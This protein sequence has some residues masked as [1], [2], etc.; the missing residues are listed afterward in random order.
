MTKFSFPKINSEDVQERFK[1]NLVG[2]TKQTKDSRLYVLTKDKTGSGSSVIRFLPGKIVDGKEN[3]PYS[4][5]YRHNLQ[6]GKGGQFVSCICPTTVSQKCPICEWNKM[7]NT[8]WVKKNNT[9]RKRKYLSNVLIMEEATEELIGKVKLMEYG[10][11]IMNI[12]ESKI[13][14]K[15]IG[16]RKKEPL[17]YYDWE[18]GANF[19]LVLS[20][21]KGQS[22]PSWDNSEFLAPT[23]I[24]EFLEDH[25]IDPETIVNNLYDTEEVVSGLDIPSYEKLKADLN[26]WCVANKLPTYSSLE[27][28]AE[29][30]GSF[31]SASDYAEAYHKAQDDIEDVTDDD[32][33]SIAGSSRDEEPEEEEQKPTASDKFRNFRKKVAEKRENN[34]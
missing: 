11:Q 17:I 6:L 12:L 8:E 24:M 22:Y 19:E 20:N 21:E 18:E 1:E 30:A 28:S 31:H 33:D 34:N 4:V 25:N 26:E 9:Y 2:K 27:N 29:N 7:M 32:L 5:I 3:L 13:Y 15:Q 14:P 16:N 10:A 23:P